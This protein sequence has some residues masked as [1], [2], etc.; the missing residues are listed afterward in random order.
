MKGEEKED[1]FDF[2]GGGEGRGVCLESN[3]REARFTKLSGG[4]RE[5]FIMLSGGVWEV[6]HTTLHTRATQTRFVGFSWI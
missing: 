5:R 6:G 1:L 3:P 2:G 4:A